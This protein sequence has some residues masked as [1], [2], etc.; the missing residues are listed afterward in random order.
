MSGTRERLMTQPTDP[1]SRAARED[2]PDRHQQCHGQEAARSSTGPPTELVNTS[3]AP[4]PRV[5]SPGQTIT[6]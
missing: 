6:A 2:D 1:L 3:I 4:M 5:D